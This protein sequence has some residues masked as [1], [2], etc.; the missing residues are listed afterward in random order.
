MGERKLKPFKRVIYKNNEEVWVC[1]WYSHQ[2]ETFHYLIGG[3][4]INKEIDSIL[5]Y[6]GNETLVGTKDNPEEECS[7]RDGELIFAASSQERIADGF[8]ILGKYVRTA[9]RGIIVQLSTGEC[10]YEYC[11]PFQWFD[12]NNKKRTR[13][14]ILTVKNYKLVKAIYK[15]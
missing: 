9:K 12:P 3:E 7:L 13:N 10:E 14:E 4:M 1:G 11:V 6:D 5:L 2:D 15:V 8:S